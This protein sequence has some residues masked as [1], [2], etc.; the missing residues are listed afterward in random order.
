VLLLFFGVKVAIWH[1]KSYY[2]CDLREEKKR[3]KTSFKLQKRGTKKL[4]V[5]KKGQKLS[6]FWPLG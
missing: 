6:S 2:F 4:K 5:R 3:K 1:S